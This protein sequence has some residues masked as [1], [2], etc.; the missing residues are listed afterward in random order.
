MVELSTQ[1]MKDAKAIVSSSG[2]NF[3]L[4]APCSL[5]LDCGNGVKFNC[6][7]RVP[8]E[9][10][11]IMLFSIGGGQYEP[12]GIRCGRETHQCS[13]QNWSGTADLTWYITPMFSRWRVIIIFHR[14][15]FARHGHN[16]TG[17]ILSAPRYREGHSR[18]QGSR[19]RGRIWSK[20]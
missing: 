1:E 2:S 5:E 9:K 7:T 6:E 16:L 14:V 17:R 12:F 19:S 8:G 3:P 18:K 4:D 20:P 10:C 15:L 13:D 11:S